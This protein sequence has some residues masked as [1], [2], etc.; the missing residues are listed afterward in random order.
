MHQRLDSNHPDYS[1]LIAYYPF[2]EGAG[3]YANDYSSYLLQ[4]NF[5][6]NL[7]WR[8]NGEEIP[9]FFNPTSFRP[10]ISFF[11]GAYIDYIINDT[12]IILSIDSSI[13]TPNTVTL[14]DIVPNYGTMTHDSIRIIYLDTIFGWEAIS[15]IYTYD[16]NGLNT[17]TIP[18]NIDS[19]INVSELTYY[20]RY[21][22]AFQIMS[23][24]T[25]YG[26]GV[27][28]GA[29]GKTWYFDVTDYAPVL[30]G[31]KQMTVSGGGQ[32]QEDLDIKFHFIVGTPPRD[33]FGNA[34]NME[35]TI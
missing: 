3:S 1:N 2:N 34:T 5:N 24:V 25:P 22:M 13:T 15:Y 17:S 27:N 18:T 7:K 12:I 35:A 30:K 8:T 9:T 19:T 14:R 33:V 29:K 10:R 11:Q 26:G 31:K 20:T 21:P 28:F 32:W 4:A 16:E 23:F 6:G